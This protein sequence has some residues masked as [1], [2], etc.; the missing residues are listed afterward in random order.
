MSDQSQGP[1][2]WLASDGKWYPP[3]THPSA[4]PPP[5]P[6]TDSV[7]GG[8]AA[9][10]SLPVRAWRKYRGWPLWAQIVAGIL[11]LALVT[12]PF[13][14]SDEP[15]EVRTTRTAS[16]EAMAETTTTSESTATTAEATTTTEEATTTTEPP[17]PPT[18]TT[19]P[20][21]PYEGESVSQR[22]ARRSASQYLDFTAFSRSGL[23]GQLE[24]EGYSTADATYAVDSLDVDWNE[25]AAKSAAQYLEFSAFSRSGL[26]DQLVFEGYTREQ[27]EYGVN[28]VGL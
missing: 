7:P 12:A 11:L 15:E 1:G 16:E 3:E 17:P 18:T 2:W 8:S 5:P 6:A 19:A 23:I 27:A 25:Q 9:R 28:A 21:D 26:I 22:N 20:P 24:F 13:A 4:A 14:G 10:G